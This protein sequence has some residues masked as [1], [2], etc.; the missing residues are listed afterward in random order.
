MKLVIPKVD[1]HNPLRN[2]PPNSQRPC[3]QSGV[4][5]LLKMVYSQGLLFLHSFVGKYIT[6]SILRWFSIVFFNPPLVQ[7]FPHVPSGNLTVCYWSHGPVEIVDLPSYKLVDFSFDIHF[8][9]VFLLK[10]HKTI[11]TAVLKQLCTSGENDLSR[12]KGSVLAQRSSS[13]IPG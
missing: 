10:S 6:S 2:T 5:R 8:P 9:M 4:E 12:F 1:F 11:L 7:K 13:W 3:H